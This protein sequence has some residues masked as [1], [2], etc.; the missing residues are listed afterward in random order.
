MDIPGHYYF[1]ASMGAYKP[2]GTPVP[3]IKLGGLDE[4]SNYELFYEDTDKKIAMTGA[5]LMKGIDIVIPASP[6]SLLISYKK[7]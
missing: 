1:T 7:V 2:D 4:K 6:G 5:E 3:T